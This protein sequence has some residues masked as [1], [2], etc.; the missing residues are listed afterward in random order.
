MATKWWNPEPPRQRLIREAVAAA[1]GEAAS[2]NDAAWVGTA[3]ALEAGA[4]RATRAAKTSKMASSAM[5]RFVSFLHANPGLAASGRFDRELWDVA[6]EAWLTVLAG[7]VT[8]SWVLP[9]GAVVMGSVSAGALVSRTAALASRLGYVG[10]GPLAWR[11]LHTARE[12]FGC[13]D[14]EEESIPTE[15]IFAWEVAAVG[16]SAVPSSVWHMCAWAMVVMAVVGGNRV[17][18]A[19][20]LL[21]SQVRWSKDD[22]ELV[23]VTPMARQK[24]QHQR[25]TNRPRRR[26]RAVALHHWLVGRFVRPWCEWHIQNRSHG[27]SL[28]FPSLVLARLAQVRTGAGQ[29]VDGGTLRL[30]PTKP[31]SSEAGRRA[32]DICLADRAG[33]RFHGLRGGNNRELR[34]RRGE[35]ADVTRRTL[36][37]RSVK[38]LLGSESSY[39]EVFL[40][41]FCEATRCLGQ[42][43]VERV[44]VLLT[45]TGFSESAG[46]LDDWQARSQPW[47]GTEGAEGSGSDGPGSED[48]PTDAESLDCGHCRAHISRRGH[49]SRCDTERCGWGLCTACWTAGPRTP[50][51]CPRHKATH[52]KRG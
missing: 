48:V 2:S 36:H 50:L 42:L 10:Q 19:Q 20:H 5:S 26:P 37:G 1:A 4:L 32:L 25:A 27:S 31:W 15:P 44:G 9:D 52:M 23:I 22:R 18:T 29:A 7:V 45:V 16:R 43:K 28:F 17:G 40:E 34:R 12:A 14:A 47:S 41:D 6:L 11:R 24:Q 35:V 8:T 39:Q 38:D 33:R 49:A 46:R 30:E 13:N 51:S 21:L 3:A